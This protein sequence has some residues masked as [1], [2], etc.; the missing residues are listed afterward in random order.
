M[1]LVSKEYCACQ[2]EGD[3]VLILSEFAGAAV[4]LRHGAILVNPYDLDR[5]ADAIRIAVAKTR[6]QRRGPMRVLRNIVR[7]EDV[8][9]WV[10]QFLGACGFA[11]PQKVSA[12][13]APTVA[14]TQQIVGIEP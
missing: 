4:Q 5:V 14:V 1:N 9:W 2:V 12:A 3:G 11:T 6:E 13:S 8:Y 7:R 10:D